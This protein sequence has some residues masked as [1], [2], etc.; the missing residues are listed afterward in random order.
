MRKQASLL[1]TANQQGFLYVIAAPSGAG[2][3]SLVKALTGLVPNLIVSISHTTRE[4]RPNETNGIDYYFVNLDEFDRLAK[5]GDFLE[6]AIIFNQRYGT[7]KKVVQDHLSK[8]I[9]VI[10]EI[11]WQGQQQI[12]QLFPDAISI[13]ILPPTMEDLEK[14]LCLRNQ[15][16]PEIIQDRLAD[17]KE[18]LA[19]IRKFDYIVINDDFD[20]ALHDLKIIIEVGRLREVRQLQK[21]A[22][23]IN[24]FLKD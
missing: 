11:D 3:T 7:S 23:L 19:H 12:K 5:K 15:D 16:R 20:R 6:H 22:D 9:D 13:F 8:G 14:R 21:H 1:S 10:L 17:A 24:G 4:R 2:K 18:T